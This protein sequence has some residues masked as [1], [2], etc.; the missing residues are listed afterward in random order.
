[1]K[2]IHPLLVIILIL[3]SCSSD[4]GTSFTGIT[5]TDEFARPIGDPDPTDWQID[6]VW[7]PQ[8]LALFP[9]VDSDMLNNKGELIDLSG[10]NKTLFVSP[11]Y[12]NPNGGNFSFLT[13]DESFLEGQIIIV[14]NSYEVIT[15]PFD[16]ESDAILFFSFEVKS[17]SA[18]FFQSD[19]IDGG[20]ETVF[21]S[22]EIIRMYYYF[23]FSDSDV[24]LK[25][26][27]DVLFE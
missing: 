11:V 5:M 17:L 22:G 10:L 1:M 14:N 7:T 15:G 25:G 18:S 27:G 23:K 3:G 12:P 8:E 13:P 19:F 26:H 6:E 4:D 21:Q 2:T 9:D 24:Y 16:L 20:D